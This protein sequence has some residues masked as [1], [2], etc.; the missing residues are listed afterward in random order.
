MCCATALL[1][2]L[3]CGLSV[4][5]SYMITRQDNHTDTRSCISDWQDSP[6]PHAPSYMRLLYMG[7]ILQDEDTLTCEYLFSSSHFT[8]F[9]LL[10]FCFLLL[11]RVAGGEREG[12]GKPQMSTGQQCRYS[13]LSLPLLFW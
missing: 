1:H 3:H 13:L 5:S 9:P 8:P 4:F 2:L 7:K 12:T 6:R 11:E 10:R